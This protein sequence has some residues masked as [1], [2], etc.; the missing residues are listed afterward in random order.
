[1]KNN[2]GRRINS[3][4]PIAG[5]AN[6]NPPITPISTPARIEKMKTETVMQQKSTKGRPL[7]AICDS[8]K[9]AR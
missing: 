6:I 5:T 2:T 9:L 7:S 8:R 3:A 1:V 4:K